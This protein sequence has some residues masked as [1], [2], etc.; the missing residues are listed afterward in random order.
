M[1]YFSLCHCSCLLLLLCRFQSEETARNAATAFSPVLARHT[2][3]RRF[4]HI[5][6]KLYLQEESSG[7]FNMT[8]RSSP[9]GDDVNGELP[10]LVVEPPPGTS[11]PPTTA[12]AHTEGGTELPA[13]VRNNFGDI[14]SPSVAD[15]D[16]LFR[17]GLVTSITQSL[18]KMYNLPNPLDR[19]AVTAN[20]NLQRLVSSY[21]DAPVT[22]VVEH[23]R[24]VIGKEGVWERR[25]RLQVHGRTFCIADSTVQVHSDYCQEL[26]E[27]GQVGLGQ[28]FRHLNVLPEFALQAAGPTEEG[29]FWRHYTL[30]CAE[31]S[32]TIQEEFIQGVWEIEPQKADQED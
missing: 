31:V 23:C 30:A 6:Q 25:V 11:L 17:D 10:L 29:G 2:T 21:Y 32:C 13:G 9:G 20:G 27:S 26:V 4:V 7:S 18:A 8:S 24:P 12:T 28:L 14:M 1:K 3:S 15:A 16:V 5:S 19:M 22:V